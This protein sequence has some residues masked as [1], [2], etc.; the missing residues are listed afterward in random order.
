M[1]SYTTRRVVR[2]IRR[3]CFISY[4]ARDSEATNQFID[5]FGSTNVIKRGITMPDEIVD[6]SDSGY[7]MRRIRERFLANST[8][9]I[10][11]VGRNTWGRRFVDWEVQASL[12]PPANGLLAVSLGGAPKLPHRVAINVASDTRGTADTRL[13][14]VS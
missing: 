4:H 9:T 7:V 11:L 8:V 6:S 13:A 14:R 3:T 5:R 1:A 2:P 12:R 10:V